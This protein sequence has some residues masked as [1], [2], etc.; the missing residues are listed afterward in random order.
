L[1][2]NNQKQ[3]IAL[4]L[5]LLFHVCGAIGILFTPY[6]QW[7]IN[8]TP[9]TLLM[10]AVLL[11]FTQ[12]SRPASFWFFI[13]LCFV[14]GIFVEIIGVNTGYLFGN[15]F[16]GEVLGPQ[17]YKVPW[18]IGINW[19]TTIFCAGSIVYRLNEWLLKKISPEM[20]PSFV[21]QLFSFVF[22]AAMI[23]TLFDWVL[24]PTAIKLGYWQWLPNGEIPF[25]NF[26]C[27]FIVSAVLLTVFRLLK[28][29]KHNQFALHLFIIQLLFFLVLQTFL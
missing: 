16:Y 2:T 29:N 25:F 24:E 9:L 3:Q 26:A 13:F 11:V 6:K 14:T 5:T 15:Y 4:L 7:F 20:Q 21:V 8:N 18:L 19:F 10:M 27:W 12:R 22:D 23:T 28:F 17:I 1:I